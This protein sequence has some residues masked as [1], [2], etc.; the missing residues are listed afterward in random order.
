MFGSNLIE[1]STEKYGSPD[2][3]R[4]KRRDEVAAIDL[5]LLFASNETNIWGRR[6]L[7]FNEPKASSSMEQNENVPENVPQ[8]S[9]TKESDVVKPSAIFFN[10]DLKDNDVAEKTIHY[11]QVTHVIEEQNLKNAEVEENL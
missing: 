1:T 9:S 3:K 10:F 11:I 7:E 6:Y 4:T 8:T 2:Y 5:E